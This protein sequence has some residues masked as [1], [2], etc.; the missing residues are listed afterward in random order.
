MKDCSELD[1]GHLH[2]AHAVSTYQQCTIKN[3][4]PLQRLQASQIAR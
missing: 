3:V 4:T 1:Q 2:A